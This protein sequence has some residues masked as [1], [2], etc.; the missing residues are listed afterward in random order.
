MTDAS[1][2]LARRSRIR[3]IEMCSRAQAAH[4]GSSLSV[5]DILAVLYSG[6]ARISPNQIDDPSR[7]Y[8]IVSKGHAAAGTY[9]ILG[10]AGYFPIEW[11]ESYG[12]DGSRLGGHVTSSVPGVELSTG[13]LGHGLPFGTGIALAAQ[14]GETG[15]RVYVVVSDGEC[16]EGTT[17]EAALFAAH[18]QLKNLTVL[19]DRNGIQSLAGTEETLKLEPFA[20][21]WRAFG[22]VVLEVDG[23]DHDQLSAALGVSKAAKDS[24]TVIVCR[25][26]KGKGVSFMENSVVWHYRPPTLDEKRSALNELN[27]TRS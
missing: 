4:I 11:L 26:T 2:G 23:H 6:G 8:V 22:W 13:S 10:E 9:A 15:Q 17:W 7:D 25:T 5:I 27:G 1:Q 12:L 16:D 21:K 24:P 18:H 20:A 19:V 3:A 14:R